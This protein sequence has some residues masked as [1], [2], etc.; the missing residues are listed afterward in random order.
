MGERGWLSDRGD[1]GLGERGWW[2]GIPSKGNN[3]SYRLEG[4]SSPLGN[5]LVIHILLGFCVVWIY[6]LLL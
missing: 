2:R 6:I 5:D 3:S 1:L 4:Q